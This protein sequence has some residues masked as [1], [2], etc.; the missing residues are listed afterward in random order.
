MDFG[1]HCLRSWGRVNL[2]RRTACE[3]LMVSLM[4]LVHR[5]VM[6]FNAWSRPDASLSLIDN[7]S[8]SNERRVSRATRR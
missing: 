8:P 7:F 2:A 6:L 5:E 4:N 3:G 1:R